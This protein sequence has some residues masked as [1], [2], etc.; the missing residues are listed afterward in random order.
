MTA[1]D[2]TFT[3]YRETECALTH[4][5]CPY[6]NRDGACNKKLFCGFTG[7][8]VTEVFLFKYSLTLL[9]SESLISMALVNESVL[10]MGNQK[11]LES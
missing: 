8:D 3:P 4:P 11:G 2:Y 7:S 5:I 10:S 1:T 6:N 9:Y